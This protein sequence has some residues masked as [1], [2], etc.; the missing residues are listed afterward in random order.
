MSRPT[1]KTDFSGEITEGTYGPAMHLTE[2]LEG[3][4]NARPVINNTIC[5]NCG[6]CYLVCPEGVIFSEENKMDIDYSF[7]KGCGICAKECRRNAITMQKED[8]A[9]E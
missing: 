2:T 4:R 9:N 6:L 1:V 5:N 8:A 7:C 3:W